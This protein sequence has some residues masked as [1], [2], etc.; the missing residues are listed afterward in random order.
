MQSQ[1]PSSPGWGQPEQQPYQQ[2]QYPQQQTG[3]PQ[4]QGQPQQPYYPPQQQQWQQ[5][6][7]MPMQQPQQPPKKKTGRI[8]GIGCGSLVALVV[9]IVIIAAAG[10]KGASTANTNQSTSTVQATS[11]A[12]TQPTSAPTSQ[13]SPTVHQTG[14]G[15]T[16]TSGA[17]SITVNS[18]K[19][20]ASG[21]E[22]EVPKAG[23]E[24]ILINMTALNTGSSPSDMNIFDFTLRDASGTSYDSTIIDVAHDPSGTVVGGQKVR[25]DLTYEIPKSVHSVTLQFD[26]PSDFDNSQ[27]VQWNLTV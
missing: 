26:D 4:W 25:G 6:P 23:D 7:M 10:N 13:P 12:T 19:Q 15:A 17:W 14:V 1:P 22:F 21:N 2:P 3:Y 8:L 5:S 11:Q 27:V 24:F 16:Q 18:I 20:T 9:L